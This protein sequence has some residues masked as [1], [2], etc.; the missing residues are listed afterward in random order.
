MF[1]GI[2]MEKNMLRDNFSISETKRVQEPRNSVITIVL[3]FLVMQIPSLLVGVV[4]GLY[5]SVTNPELAQNPSN[6]QIQMSDEFL[7]MS[8]FIT[9]LITIA[10]YIFAKKFLNRNKASL[11]LTKPNKG[12]NYIKGLAYGFIMLVAAVAI[13]KV[14]GLIEFN[15]N[16]SNV[17]P[18]MFILFIIGWMI[19]GFEEEFVTRAV[20]MNFFA[21][22]NTI[23][24][25][26]IANSLIFSLLHL[27]NNAFSILPFINIF[28]VG[29][30]FSLM[31]YVSDDIFLPAAAHSIWN[32]AQG[33]LFGIPVSGS[34]NV[35]NTLVRSKLV[36]NELM[37]G[38]AFGVEGGLAVTIVEVIAIIILIKMAKDKKF[39]GV[40]YQV[41]DLSDDNTDKIIEED[42]QKSE[43]IE[44][45]SYEADN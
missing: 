4:Y 41:A 5:T 9:L 12:K 26:I 7:L 21:A 33:N 2:K 38:G 40:E 1:I 11:G 44:K 45:T 3:L 29:V 20:V 42:N 22:K 13:L 34:F 8:L 32:F 37:T 35:E 18:L 28:L 10:V 39:D 17:S 15:A 36:G 16:F 6:F 31:F 30:V 14:F 25:G 27:G 43:A 24:V 23:I 19:Q